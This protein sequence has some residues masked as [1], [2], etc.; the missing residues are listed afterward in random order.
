[1]I[2]RNLYLKFLIKRAI[3]PAVKNML[4]C[5]GDRTDLYIDRKNLKVF[6]TVAKRSRS[7]EIC[8][9]CRKSNKWKCQK[10]YMYNTET[11]PTLV[12][13]TMRDHV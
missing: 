10:Y 3:I 12:T 11:K 1:M 2:L 9:Y 4:W 13:L 5:Y 8:Q 6:I 7:F